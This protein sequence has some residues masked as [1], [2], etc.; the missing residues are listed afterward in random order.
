MISVYLS[1]NETQMMQA[2]VNARKVSLQSC[3]IIPE[4]FLSAFDNLDHI[5]VERLMSLFAEVKDTVP[6]KHDTVAVV[7]PDYLFE[8]IDCFSYAVEAE[9]KEH[10]AQTLH[11][12]LAEVYISM[13]I[14][15]QPQPLEKDVTV[16]VIDCRIV[17]AL[18]EAAKKENVYLESIEPASVSYLRCSETFLKEELLWFQYPE[19]ATFLAFSSICGLFKMDVPQL[20]KKQLQTLHEEEAEKLIVATLAELDQTALQTF[21]FFNKEVPLVIFDNGHNRF[22]GMRSRQTEPRFFPAYIQNQNDVVEEEMQQ[23]VMPT[24][25]AFLQRFDF[26]DEA[27]GVTDTSLTFLS[28]NLLP[29]AVKHHTSTFL[30]INKSQHMIKVAACVLFV[31]AIMEATGILFLSNTVIPDSLK[32]DYQAA[33]SS[34]AAINKELDIIQLYEKEDQQ[35]LV[36]YQGIVSSRPNGLGFTSVEIGAKARN[37]W[38]KVRVAAKDPLVFQDYVTALAKGPLFSNVTIKAINSDGSG[39]KTADISIGRR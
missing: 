9:I 24:V 18:V 23:A 17:D 21:T 38:I 15:S 25:G 32:E 30:R 4:S 26:S 7:L 27:F 5:D 3:E 2:N 35:V 28:G 20:S 19:H 29:E 8:M 33:Q 34:M 31:V 14:F 11:R 10:I 12:S 36:G 1:S 6:V 16:C 39:Y 37:E 13:P 22:S